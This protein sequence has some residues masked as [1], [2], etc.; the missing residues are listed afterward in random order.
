MEQKNS[1]EKNIIKG[2]RLVAL[3]APSGAGKSTIC[4]QLIERNPEFRLSISAT[5]RPPRKNEI[6]GVHYYFLSPEAFEA[7]IKSGDFLEY[8][9]VHD[10]FYGTLKSTVETF[11]CEGYTVLFD[12]D[13]NGALKIKSH[14]P[15][16][17]LIFIKPPSMEELVRRLKNRKTEDRATI[18]RRLQRLP[19]EYSKAELFDVQIV[20]DDL[21]RAVEEI[22]KIIFAR[23]KNNLINPDKS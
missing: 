17:L 5:T 10:N 3:S 15:E 6:D 19:L 11:L 20:N 22:E 23:Q 2:R 7:K 21:L 18:E 16:S 14:Y 13:V 4:H 8:E 1:I 12:I 9:K